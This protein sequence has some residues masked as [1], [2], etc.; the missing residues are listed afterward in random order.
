MFSYFFQLGNLPR[1]VLFVDWLF[2]I[3]FLG[4]LRLC[5]RLFYR[6]RAAFDIERLLSRK[7]AEF[8]F[9]D[10]QVLAE[11]IGQVL[12]LVGINDES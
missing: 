11:S 10:A 8:D 1:S 5:Y 6:K 7:L 3:V 2:L 4:A 12:D 9:V